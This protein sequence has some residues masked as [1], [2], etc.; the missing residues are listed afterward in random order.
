MN[1]LE[2]LLYGAVQGITEYLP[3]SSSA[4][5]ILVP[6]FLK[7]PD[8]GLSFDVFLHLGTLCS[9]LLFFRE[10]WA[11]V[12]R[13][14]FHPPGKGEQNLFLLILIGTIPALIAGALIHKQ[15]ETIFRGNQVLMITLAV[16]GILLFGVDF[17]RE[18]VTPVGRP[19]TQAG[20]KDAI[21]IGISQCFALVPGMSRSGSTM[22]GGRLMGLDRAAAARF[23]F[24]LSAPVTAA[25]LIFELRKYREL[26]ESNV[27]VPAMIVGGVSSFVFGFLAIGGMLK[28]LKRFGYLSFAIYRV[29]L[30]FVIY[31]VLGTDG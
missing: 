5:L 11:M 27:G 1:L 7:T 22:I 15:A 25:A 16:G 8:P 3:V 26:L 9:T 28:L 29:A 12:F 13:Q 24:L 19:I 31:K 20:V 21:W 17:W 30:S 23:S 4:H 14:A 6:K 18:H 10:D 2:A